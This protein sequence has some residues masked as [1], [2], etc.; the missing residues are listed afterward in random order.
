[1][2]GR[3]RERGIDGQEREKGGG[4]GI[5]IRIWER[6]RRMGRRYAGGQER[7]E[8]ETAG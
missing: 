1:L 8:R 2:D 7:R 5:V 6:E 4:A 3:K